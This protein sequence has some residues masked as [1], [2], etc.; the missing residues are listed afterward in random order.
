MTQTRTTTVLDRAPAGP[1]AGT[2]TFSITMPADW[3][4]LDL[5][6]DSTPASVHRLVDWAAPHAGAAANTVGVELRVLLQ[7]AAAEARSQGAVLAAVYSRSFDG[8][9]VSASV[10][11]A[12]TT[13]AFSDD[14]ADYL[15][16][17]VA[18]LAAAP[19]ADETVTEAAV[20]PIATGEA[21]R[22]RKR[23]VVR[24]SGRRVTT[25]VVQYFVPCPGTASTV[26]L[27]FST[28]VLPLA[29]AFATLFD[30]IAE[31]LEWR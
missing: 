7:Q 15:R 1:S 27:T 4:E 2:A 3:L 21:V 16:L 8:H 29:D 11:A 25:D 23:V 10:I 19:Y 26:V 12:V 13:T 9:P 30:A 6:P 28:P 17:L 5:D 20:V 14:T 24:A 22:C 18:H 31:T